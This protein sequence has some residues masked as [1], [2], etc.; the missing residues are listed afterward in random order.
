[1][2]STAAIFNYWNMGLHCKEV[3]KIEV[4]KIAEMNVILISWIVWNPKAIIRETDI[5]AAH[6]NKA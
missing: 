2:E 3:L 6:F 4:V 1:M 5:S